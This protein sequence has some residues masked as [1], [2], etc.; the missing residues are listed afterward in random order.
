MAGVMLRAIRRRSRLHD[1]GYPGQA[2]VI[3]ALDTWT[4]DAPVTIL[5]GD[6]GSGK[7]TLMELLAALTRAV[8]ID[9]GAG[10]KAPK[11]Q[12]CQRCAEDFQAVFGMKPRRSFFFQAE[13]FIRYL[14]RLR[15]MREDAQ[16]ALDGLD[17]AY[18]GRSN[19]ARMLA[20][21]PHASALAEMNSLYGGSMENRS[22]GEGFLD[23]F[24]ARL[25][26]GG[27]YLLDEPEGALSYVNQMAMLLLMQQA[28]ATGCQFIV[29]THSPV[30]AA[31][32]GAA[33]LELRDG[34]LQP[35]T[36]EQLESIAFLKRFL[37][38]RDSTLQ[39]FGVAPDA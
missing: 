14:D 13:D 4:L 22:H 7:T 32:P 28:V 27:L 24:R 19:Y 38:A 16:D 31:Y 8:R 3:A 2:E 12:A 10:A 29:A 36:Y 20:A 30:L 15:A 35:C 23:F 18:E 34:A 6:N 25:H 26:P 9:G 17:A 33:L 37:A 11:Q 39:L 5:C 21:M 1:A